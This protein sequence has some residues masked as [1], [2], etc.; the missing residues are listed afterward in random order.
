MR[1]SRF[2]AGYF[3]MAA[4]KSLYGFGVKKFEEMK[5]KGDYKPED[6]ESPE[7]PYSLE[8]MQYDPILTTAQKEEIQDIENKDEAKA[9]YTE[10]RAVGHLIE[11]ATKKLKNKDQQA[12]KNEITE[13]IDKAY[14]DSISNS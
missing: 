1:L 5:N 10:S 6:Y 4:L 12:F 8:S 2:W 11:I 14:K 3:G 13:L 9:V 7:E